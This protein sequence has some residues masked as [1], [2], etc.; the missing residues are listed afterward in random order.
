MLWCV[1]NPS[2]GIPKIRDLGLDTNQVWPCRTWVF[3]FF[4]VHTSILLGHLPY[5]SLTLGSI[6]PI[7]NHSKFEM[8]FCE[9]MK[10]S[11]WKPSFFS[12]VTIR[13]FFFPLIFLYSQSSNF[14]Q[15]CLAK[16]GYRLD[17]KVEIL[18]INFILA[19]YWNLL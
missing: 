4:L 7:N 16:S 6:L 3:A 2:D 10:L 1:E 13:F 19:T 14:P 12:Q 18:R 5:I 8:K 15:E 9:N 11:C 17:L